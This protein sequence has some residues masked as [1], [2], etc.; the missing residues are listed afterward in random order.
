VRWG[1]EAEHRAPF[2]LDVVPDGTWRAGLDRTLLGAAVAEE[3][4]RLWQDTLPLDD[5]DSGA[6]DLAGR[7]AELVDRLDAARDALTVPQPMPAGRRPSPARPTR[8]PPRARATPGSARSCT[9]SSTTWCA[10]RATSG[11][12]SPP[13]RSGTSSPTGWPAARPGRTSGRAP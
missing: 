5:V 1:I 3:G 7:F 11:W 10:T 6:I 8:S 9:A 2:R 12:R 13:R 4:H